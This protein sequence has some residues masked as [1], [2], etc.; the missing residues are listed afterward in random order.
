MVAITRVQEETGS[1]SE[2]KAVPK[3]VVIGQTLIQ[4]I[5]FI[6]S[7]KNVK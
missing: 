5:V 4:A 6:R 2:V 7:G 1:I 3:A